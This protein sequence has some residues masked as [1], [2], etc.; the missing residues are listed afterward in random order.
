MSPSNSSR[1]PLRQGDKSQIELPARSNGLKT[2]KIVRRTVP[3][4]KWSYPP[5]IWDRMVEPRHIIN[6]FEQHTN[7]VVVQ[8]I[9]SRVTFSSGKSEKY[10]GGISN[11]M[12]INPCRKVGATHLLGSGRR[13]AYL[14]K[15]AQVNPPWRRRSCHESQ[16]CEIQPDPDSVARFFIVSAMRA[17]GPGLCGKIH[18][19]GQS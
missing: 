6:R 14:T 11:S 3:P 12:S 17:V 8:E 9:W 2:G 18:H 4:N 5:S 16:D 13:C 1:L 10:G 15:F 19:S 7:R